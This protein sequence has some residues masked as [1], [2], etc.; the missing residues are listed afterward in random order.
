MDNGD[1]PQPDLNVLSNPLFTGRGGA[2]EGN[3]APGG[4]SLD[5]QKLQQLQLQQQH[6]NQLAA[7]QKLAPQDQ[8][9]VQMQ[10]QKQQ[11]YDPE[12]SSH[13]MLQHLPQNMRQQ[14]QDML[15]SNAQSH[16][17]GTQGPPPGYPHQLPAGVKPSGALGSMGMTRGMNDMVESNSLSTAEGGAYGSY[18]AMDGR[19]NSQMMPGNMYY[20]GAGAMMGDQAG[21]GLGMRSY[22]GMDWQRQQPLRPDD[23]SSWSAAYGQPSQFH[24]GMGSYYPPQG[25]PYY[26]PQPLQHQQ[27]MWHQQAMA[28][29]YPGG[30]QPAMFNGS[31]DHFPPM[32]MMP[33]HDSSG[34]TNSA[35]GG[36]SLGQKVAGVGGPAANMSAGILR[37]GVGGGYE[38]VGGGGKRPLNSQDSGADELNQ[39]D[40]RL[41]ANKIPRET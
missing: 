17:Y 41:R 27:H 32:G 9:S 33:A 22:A 26:A 13:D 20:P 4:A 10:Y 15:H 23:Y 30:P 19:Y 5:S 2:V 8:E 16:F 37:G 14:Q 29:H 28:S 12:G 35:A 1:L 6:A 24:R 40:M 39:D 25:G 18:G 7:Q 36:L 31:F 38:S 21:G 34:G 3:S 11:Q